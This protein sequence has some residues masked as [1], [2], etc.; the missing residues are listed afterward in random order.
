M[1]KRHSSIHKLLDYLERVFKKVN[2]EVGLCTGCFQ[3]FPTGKLLTAPCE[4]QYCPSCLRRMSLTALNSPEMFPAKC[5]SQEIPTKAVVAVMNSQN[6]KRYIVR[7]EENNV[8][9]LE[10]LYCPR[11][12]CGGW[13]PPRSP[14]AR[15]GYRVCPHCRAKVCSKC[16]DFFHLGWSCSHDSDTKAT[17][18]LAKENNW[19]RCSNCLYLVEKVDGCN[20]MI[21]SYLCGQ[22]GQCECPPRGVENEDLDTDGDFDV[23]TLVA[24]MEQAESAGEPC[25]W[26][27]EA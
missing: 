12:T 20:H 23:D 24:A 14:G 2:G 27:D 26:E 3:K 4:H 25:W 22:R 18:R 21:C 13:I 6:K 9:P 16:G 5:C 7:W 8:P 19:Q 17:L 10:R 11:A 1:P 15:L